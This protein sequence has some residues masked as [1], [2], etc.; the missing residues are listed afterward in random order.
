ME[1]ALAW[2]RRWNRCDPQSVLWFM[3]G[4][5]E[6]LMFYDLPERWWRVSRTT[7]RVER[8]I[9]TL[10][11][12]LRPMGTF[13]DRIEAGDMFTFR[14]HFRSDSRALV[15]RIRSILP[16]SDSP[17]PPNAPPSG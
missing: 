1:M 6:S 3:E 16:A 5:S 11:M 15:I 13:H 4:F 10:R 8:L 9:R 12:R 14:R 17:A 2:Q 7:N